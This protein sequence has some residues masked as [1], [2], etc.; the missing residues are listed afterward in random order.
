MIDYQDLQLALR[1]HVETLSV[2]TTGTTT[3]G[4]TGSTFTRS[5][6]SFITDG[7]SA[8][9]EVTGTGFGATN[10]AAHIVTAVA[11]LSL[12]V[13]G[14]LDTEVAAGSRSLAVGLPSRRAWENIGFDPEPGYP[15]IEEQLVP[16]PTRVP[17]IGTNGTIVAEPIYGITVHAVENTGIGAANR[18]VG[19]L[20]EHFKPGTQVNLTNGD[21]AEVRR[22]TGPFP[23]PKLRTRPGW[24][25]VPV[26]FPLRLYTIN[27]N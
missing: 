3:L 27:S 8:G 15:W 20:W 12:T 17:T 13:S 1:A 4:A 10:N 24:V 7:F 5:A 11:A 16:G 19:A 22:D 18:Y 23:S 21:T 6:G 2:V 14:T 9:M 25:T 26:S